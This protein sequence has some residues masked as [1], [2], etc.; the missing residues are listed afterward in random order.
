M[1]KPRLKPEY[2]MLECDIID[3]LLGGL[4]EWRP[5]LSYP[6]S[7][8]D[9]QG[10]VRALL[11]MYQVKRRALAFSEDELLLQL[12][13]CVHGNE[14]EWL[15]GTT[16]ELGCGCVVRISQGEP[17]RPRGVTVNEAEAKA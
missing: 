14:Y 12:P 2:A 5:D 13:K 4:K 8:S 3:T 10:C 6:E 11:R 17:H 15:P 1:S 16:L 9:M 7:H